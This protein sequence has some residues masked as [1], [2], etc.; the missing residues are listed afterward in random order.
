MIPMVNA[1]E[2]LESRREVPALL[3]ANDQV[4]ITT[5]VL[6][7]SPRYTITL[8]PGDG[9]EGHHA[10][11]DEL[12]EVA[13]LWPGQFRAFPALWPLD[14]DNE[15]WLNAYL[16]SGASG[17]K[18]YHGNGGSHGQGPFACVAVDDP[19]LDPVLARC[20]REAIPVIFHVNLLL[21]EDLLWNL[22]SRFP[23]LHLVVPHLML[24]K[25]TSTRLARVADLL[26][27]FPRLYTDL[28]FGRPDY[29]ADA[30][31]SITREV[32]LFRGFVTKWA[33]RIM[34]GSD[35]VV[36]AGK[37]KRGT[38]I[39]DTLQTYRDLCERETFETRYC[40]GET[41]IGLA[42]PPRV[43]EQLYTQTFASLTEAGWGDPCRRAGLATVQG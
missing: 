35:M 1:H 26:T 5:T 21:F 43:L 18:L 14:P 40:P 27:S 33:G 2:H 30:L 11:N 4:S 34:V 23:R 24:A 41:L 42:L 17:I 12:L 16:A 7:G 22:L 31:K 37:V 13:R 25:R 15:E 28:S 39:R 19:R 8:K 36:T 38:F 29:L 3:K 20:E 10:N 9:F 6:V 32:E